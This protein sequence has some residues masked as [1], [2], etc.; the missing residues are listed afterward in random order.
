LAGLILGLLAT[1]TTIARQDDDSEYHEQGRA[2]YN[3]RCYFCHGYSGDARTLT[4]TYVNP[5]PRDFTNTPLE[6]LTRGQM[7]HTVTHGKNKTAMHGF[8]RL[9]NKKEI[10]SVVDFVRLE[11]MENKKENTRYHTLENGWG[12]HQR[13]A[14]AFPFASG[15]IA[16]DTPWESLTPEQVRGKQLFLTSCITCH[17]R[18]IVKDEGVMWKKQAISYPRNNYSHT[19]ID[20]ISSASIYAKHDIVPDASHFSDEAREGQHLWEDNCAFCHGSDGTGENWIGSFLDPQP[21]N[22]S[23]PD[24]MNM[25]NRELLTVRIK[26]GLKNT[27]MPAWKDV[28]SEQQIQQIISYISEAFHPV[29]ETKH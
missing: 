9:L 24:F 3:Y 12:N 1:S 7:I 28:L 16:L 15:E 23:D 6:E 18:A 21:R 29:A 22:L 20:A 14:I 11:F 2:I 19:E 17:D 4:T 27:S 26:N 5:K 13:Y 8:S 25:M 10:E